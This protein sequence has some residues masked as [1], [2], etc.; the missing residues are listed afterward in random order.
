M[1]YLGISS[2]IY[3]IG[4][5][6]MTIIYYQNNKENDPIWVISK[7]YVQILITWPFLILAVVSFLPYLLINRIISKSW[8]FDDSSEIIFKSK[9]KDEKFKLEMDRLLK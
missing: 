9:T 7:E 2:I 4:M 6:L 8:D 3:L 5:A 1:H